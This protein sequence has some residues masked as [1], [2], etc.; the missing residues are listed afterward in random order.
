[1][2]EIE[3]SVAAGVGY[4]LRGGHLVEQANEIRTLAVAELDR[5]KQEH[6]LG[7]ADITCLDDAIAV[8][9]KG[10][11]D[12]TIAT[13]EAHLQTAEQATAMH[14][15]KADRKRLT[16]CVVRAFRHSPELANFRRDTYQGTTIANFCTDLHR[17][18]AFAKEHEAELAPVGAGKEFQAAMETKLRALESDSGAQEAAIASLP[19]NNR[20][21]CE[22]KG[23]LY[24]LIKD[25]INAA[26]ALH[27]KE[28]EAAAKYNLK[29]L[30]RRGVKAKAEVSPTPTPAK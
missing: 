21:F 29:V 4:R 25:I 19:D 10:L 20:A 12:R 16:E 18:L 13:G 15:L 23:R 28:P 5:F 24:F 22:A 3:K 27:N 8:V 7:D 17:K 26:R 1:M 30:Y 9:I 2:A 6:L 14:D 11:H